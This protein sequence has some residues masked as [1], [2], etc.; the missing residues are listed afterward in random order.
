MKHLIDLS[1]TI[2]DGLVTYKDLPAPVI[3]DYLSREASKAHYGEGVSFQIGKI[4][5][6][7]NTGTY[8]DSPFHRY[9]DG[10]DLSEL[11]LSSMAGL[12][13]IVFRMD[14]TRISPDIFRKKDL[15]GKSGIDSHQLV[16]SLDYRT[17]LRKSPIS[18]KRCCRI[19][20]GS[21]CVVGWN[22]FIQY[23]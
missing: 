10:N 15:W 2:E 9:S 13:G 16:S 12:E 20:N 6:V 8:I 18:H 22:R 1:H 14:S 21:R 4:E 17:I 5:M 7:A 11:S 19:F 3:S 23:R